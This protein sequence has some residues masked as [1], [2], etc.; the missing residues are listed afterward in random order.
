MDLEIKRPIVTKD[1]EAMIHNHWAIV[2]RGTAVFQ[3][4]KHLTPTKFFA[5]TF[6]A[7]LF[8]IAPGSRPMFRS[9]MTVQGKAL[10]GL[11]AVM[12]TVM[13][14]D[15][16]VETCQDLARMHAR[17]GATKAHYSS[18][19][20][21]LL[22]TLEIVSGPEWSAEIRSAY[23]TSYCLLYYLML[24]VILE[25]PRRPIQTSLPGH[26]ARKDALGANTVRL[27]IVLDFPL[28]YH[29]GDSIL[30]GVP[31]PTGEVR[32][33]YVITSL[34][35]PGAS[36]FEICVQAIGEASKWLCAASLDAAVNVY[37]INPGVHFETDTFTSIPHRLLF[38]SHGISVA[39]FFAMIKGLYAIKSQYEGDVAALQC[40]EGPPIAYFQRP[41]EGDWANCH[42]VTA[43]KFTVTGALDLT[44]DLAQRHLY[45]SG[46]VEFVQEATRHFI[47]AGG[48][49]SN[50]VVY[51][52]DN[53]PFIEEAASAQQMM[54][55]L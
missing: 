20:T 43:A 9:S 11:V 32:R 51:S 2:C 28:R 46:P 41:F 54:I 45:I 30:L 49:E 19:G 3:K 26:I 22:E 35:S 23:L 4:E 39:P 1:H 27:L 8:K 36:T 6:Y 15:N 13:K 25:T 48:A 7:T 21:A 38:I 33:S 29:P 34:H 18:V 50:I 53:T 12:A 37:W 10:T 55:T 31:L 47:E 14:A 40:Y 52:F 5:K 16:V 44:P 24:P 17:F 42:I